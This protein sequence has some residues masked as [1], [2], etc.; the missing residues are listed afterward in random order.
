MHKLYYADTF[1]HVYNRGTLRSDIFFDEDDY[2]YS[3][4][5]I[6]KFKNKY[7]VKLLC[8]CLMRNHF[9]FF[10]K[11]TKDNLTI[12]KFIGDL[13]NGHTKFI[14]KKYQRTGV[15][16]EGPA[17]SKFL[18]DKTYHEWFIEYIMLNPVIAGLSDKAENWKYST[19]HEIANDKFNMLTDIDELVTI[20]GSIEKVKEKIKNLDMTDDFDKSGLF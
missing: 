10:L 3:L 13:Q 8:Y 4:N 1:H 6:D 5:R 11:Q 16:F 17:K 19:A 12:G 18:S 2:D 20:F 9:H 15:F 7:D 14:N